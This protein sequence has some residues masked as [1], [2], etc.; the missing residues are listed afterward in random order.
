CVKF[1]PVADFTLN[2][3]YQ[4]NAPLVFLLNFVLLM[5]AAWAG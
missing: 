5:L 3:L 2:V 1:A 4:Q